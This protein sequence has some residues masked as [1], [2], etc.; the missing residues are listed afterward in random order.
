VALEEYARDSYENLL[1]SLCR[2]KEFVGSYPTKV[3]VVGFDFKG[4][5]FRDLHRRAIGF[6][7]SNFTYVGLR[8]QHPKFSH[9]RAA[10]GEQTAINNFRKDMYGCLNPDLYTKRSIRDP[11]MR[12]VPYELACP[13]LKPLLEWR[14]PEQIDPDLL[15]WGRNDTIYA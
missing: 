10:E 7:A 15:P 5:R 6:P 12:T 13:E 8:P 2:F 4:Q 14:G 1:F 3:T 11:F 9:T